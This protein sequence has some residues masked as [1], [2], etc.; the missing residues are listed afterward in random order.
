[1]HRCAWCQEEMEM[2][3]P[4]VDRDPNSFEEHAL[5]CASCAEVSEELT[6]LWYIGSLYSGKKVLSLSALAVA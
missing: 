3:V 1:M 4:V 5:V 6:P 2:V